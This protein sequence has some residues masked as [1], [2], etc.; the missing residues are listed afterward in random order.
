MKKN[1]VVPIW[2]ENSGGYLRGIK[3]CG[4]SATEKRERHRKRE[5]DKLASTTKSIVDLFLTQIKKNELSNIYISAISLSAIFPLKNTDDLNH[6]LE[7]F[8]I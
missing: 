3:G 2:K 6:K 1:V 5:L 8:T 7:Q 4:S